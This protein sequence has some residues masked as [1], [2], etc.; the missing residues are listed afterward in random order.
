VGRVWSIGL[1]GDVLVAYLAART[2]QAVALLLEANSSDLVFYELL[3]KGF[4]RGTVPVQDV[5]LAILC[6]IDEPA[7]PLLFALAIRAN[8]VGDKIFRLPF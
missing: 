2:Y 1:A 7:L 5:F 8:A 3:N 6:E 4:L